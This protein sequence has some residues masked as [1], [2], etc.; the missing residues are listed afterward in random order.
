MCVCVSACVRA[1]VCVCAC[2][3]ACVRA[4]VSVCVSVCVR[5]CARTRE[6]GLPERLELEGCRCEASPPSQDAWGLSR[7]PRR[8]QTSWGPLT[9]SEPV[10]PAS[11]RGRGRCTSGRA[12]SGIP[13][14]RSP[15][16]CLLPPRPW[17]RSPRALLGGLFPAEGRAIPP[18]PG[19]SGRPCAAADTLWVQ[20]KA[21]CR[22]FRRQ[23]SPQPAGGHGC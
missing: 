23:T 16:P 13:G 5:A 2:V 18:Q 11:P 12:L 22:G 1:W 9:S 10:T 19:G 6:R 3:C 14:L 17:T 7:S 15:P 20:Q 4:C 21:G 8:Q